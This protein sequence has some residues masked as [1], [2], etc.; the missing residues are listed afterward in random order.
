M[1]LR[2]SIINTLLRRLERPA[3]AK[4][5]DVESGRARMLGQAKL[6]ASTPGVYFTETVLEHGELSVD[7]VVCH[8]PKTKPRAISAS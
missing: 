6:F 4:M 3:L 7:A 8:P 5:P 1:S 2:L